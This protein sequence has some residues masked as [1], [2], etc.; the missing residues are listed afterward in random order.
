MLP[1]LEQVRAFIAADAAQG[2]FA[3]WGLSTVID[4]N[5]G[6]AVID[7]ELFDVLHETAGIAAGF[8]VGNAGVIHVYAYWFSTAV[9]P[10]GYKRD[11]WQDGILASA[12]GQVPDAFR[13]WG[14]GA[15]TPL[16]RVTAATLPLL[17][18]P[19]SAVRGRADAVVDGTLTRVV[20]VGADDPSA[21]ALIYGTRSGDTWRLV[22]AFPISGHPDDV[23]DDFLSDQRWRWNAVGDPQA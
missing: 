20:L 1:D 23:V 21:T 19:P 17:T 2:R 14:D 13:L 5:T 6:E 18:D 7:R 22:T 12:L 9:T 16:Q 10:Y 4:E 3:H 8:P 15:S 11:R